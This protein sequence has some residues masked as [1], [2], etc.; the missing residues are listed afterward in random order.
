M[1]LELCDF[2]LI[3]WKTIKQ[4]VIYRLTNFAN[5]VHAGGEKRE[6]ANWEVAEL[7]QKAAKKAAQ[8]QQT[9][10]YLDRKAKEE[11]AARASELFLTIGTVA[12]KTSN[13]RPDF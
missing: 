1:Y 11:A 5:F 13:F 3:S 4:I 6:L 12:P 8:N 7:A 2:V 10:E 9:A